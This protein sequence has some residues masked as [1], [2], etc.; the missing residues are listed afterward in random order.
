MISPIDSLLTR[1]PH[2][3]AARFVDEAVSVSNGEVLCHGRVPA[4]SPYLDGDVV[5]SFVALEVAAQVA[6]GV[7]AVEQLRAQVAPR[8]KLELSI[9]PVGAGPEG[10]DVLE[11]KGRLDLR[12]GSGS[13]PLGPSARVEFTDGALGTV[14]LDELAVQPG[15]KWPRVKGSG[16]LVAESDAVRLEPLVELPPGRASVDAT[17]EVDEREGHLVLEGL[18]ARLTS[19]EEG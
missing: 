12:F 11:G 9:S 5:P 2:L 4:N 8:S 6:S 15:A 14:L 1:L 13:V 18:S 19:R 16:H 7:V 17:F 3:G 10:L